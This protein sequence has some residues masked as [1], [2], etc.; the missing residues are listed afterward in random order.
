MPNSIV[1]Q[2]LI[3]GGGYV[4]LPLAIKCAQ[5][6]YLTI[7][8]DSNEEKCISLRNG[9]SGIDVES[10]KELV[11]LLGLKK[12]QVVNELP[13]KNEN[14]N[15]NPT[16]VVICVPTPVN[17]DKK[18]VLEY[19]K[20]ACESATSVIGNNTILILESSTYPGTTRELVLPILRKKWPLSNEDELL[21]AYSPERVDPG[22]STWNVSN[23]PRLVSGLNENSV[24]RCESFYQSL[25]IMTKKVSSIEVAEAAK[26]FENAFRLVNI[27]FVN[28]FAT[29]LRKVGL[30]PL[31][32][33]DAA[34]SKPFGIMKF[35]PSAG[36]GGHCIPVD[37]YYLT[38]WISQKNLALSMIETA[39]KVNE[40]MPRVAV[41]RINEFFRKN[42]THI[43]GKTICLVGITYKPGIADLRESPAEYIYHELEKQYCTIFWWDPMIT[44]WEGKVRLNENSKIDLYV[45][46]TNVDLDEL[47]KQF[48][49]QL[50]LNL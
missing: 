19:V 12:I 18:P 41:E 26:L 48:Q 3:I 4:G 6:G 35:S 20:S 33:L 47:D 42:N 2:V 32:I 17:S 9:I 13:N 31:E 22:N 15:L 37:P 34:Y 28:E 38:W 5:N 16:F 40:G 7:I 49:P 30:N 11:K 43:F 23:T 50:N 27:S 10:D 24:N 29:V 1:N 25:G 46:V 8:F 21:L 36:V 44:K 14:F 39:E 45:I